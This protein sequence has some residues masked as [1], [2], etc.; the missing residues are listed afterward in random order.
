MAEW[1][2]DND[3]PPRMPE[4]RCLIMWRKNAKV[5][6]YNDN[7]WTPCTVLKCLRKDIGQFLVEP[8]RGDDREEFECSVKDMRRVHFFENIYIPNFFH[9]S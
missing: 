4:H 9:V 3:I 1:Y 8:R 6:V 5:D 7:Y 2:D